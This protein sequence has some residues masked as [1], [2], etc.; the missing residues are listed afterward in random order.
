M[1]WISGCRIGLHLFYETAESAAMSSADGRTT[2]QECLSGLPK[3][4]S[5]WEK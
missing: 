4:Q 5:Q 3:E 2:I 1:K